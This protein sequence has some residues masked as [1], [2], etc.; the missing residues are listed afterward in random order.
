MILLLMGVSGSGKTTL[1]QRL[2]AELGWP[3]Y[4]G[5]DFHPGENIE[6]MARG[7]PLTDEDRRPWL[8]RLAA[9]LADLLS[10]D[11][12]AVLACSALKKRYRDL[13]LVDQRVKLVYL[14]GDYQTLK[15]RLEGRRGHFMKADLL[16]SQLEALEE[17]APEE[18]LSLSIARSPEELS[19][20]IKRSLGLS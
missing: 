7:V 18:A 17:P 8:E 19:R 13:L 2:A 15:R 9:L 14:K 5:D 16:Q 10:R 3:F 4:E 20:E 11:E 1:G 12:S 6:K